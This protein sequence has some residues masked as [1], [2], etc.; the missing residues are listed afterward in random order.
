MKLSTCNLLIDFTNGISLKKK[1][2]N[3]F[4]DITATPG[5]ILTFDIKNLPYSTNSSHRAWQ[6]L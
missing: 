1:K 4:I 6:D 3:L 5:E 2:F